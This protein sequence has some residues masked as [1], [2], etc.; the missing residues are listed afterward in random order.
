MDRKRGRNSSPGKGESPLG[1][2]DAIHLLMACYGWTLPEALE[3]TLPQL[4][5]LFEAIG[6][7]PPINFIAPSLLKSIGD[8]SGAMSKLQAMGG[9]VKV[10]NK[11]EMSDFI[12]KMTGGNN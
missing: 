11:G 4:R 8:K 10:A 6:K 9:N 12:E 5:M 3:I 7:F 2:T 1:L